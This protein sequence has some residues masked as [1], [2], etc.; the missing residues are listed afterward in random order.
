MQGVERPELGLYVPP[1]H[2][3]RNPA[4]QYSPGPH[5]WAEVR[6]A[7]AAGATGKEYHPAGTGVG[8]LERA[9]QYL[10]V[11]KTRVKLKQNVLQGKWVAVAE[12]G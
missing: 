4:I 11:C 10:D 8:I 2:E 7:A 9:G 6:I 5:C 3:Y 12:A 1:A